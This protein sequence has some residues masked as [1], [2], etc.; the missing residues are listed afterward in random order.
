MANHDID[1]IRGA[2]AGVPDRGVRLVRRGR[3]HRPHLRP[4]PRTSG[5]FVLAVLSIVLTFL[6]LLFA[7]T[8]AQ[9]AAFW[10]GDHAQDHG[11]PWPV[12][13]A[14]GYRP[15]NLGGEAYLFHAMFEEFRLLPW[16]VIVAVLTA[17]VARPYQ[18]LVV[19]FGAGIVENNWWLHLATF[20][21]PQ[22]FKDL[23]AKQRTLLEHH[24]PWQA[25]GILLVLALLTMAWAE[26]TQA[27]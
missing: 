11:K 18:A 17:A 15:W 8:A 26:R 14:L 27:T 2:I 3:S 22:W 1:K 13:R 6:A 7:F 23:V 16:F 24:N 12:F 5:A 25:F 21:F 19:A 9:L 10:I 20:D 4:A